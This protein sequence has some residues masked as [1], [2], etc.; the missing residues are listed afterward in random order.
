MGKK[1][2]RNSE[3]DAIVVRELNRGLTLNDVRNYT[4]DREAGGSSW[5]TVKVWF[6]D[7]PS[8]RLL[9]E[10]WPSVSVRSGEVIPETDKE[11]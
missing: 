2:I 1:M 11:E 4:I 8:E 3:T 10:P 5:L 7:E 6:Q 9:P